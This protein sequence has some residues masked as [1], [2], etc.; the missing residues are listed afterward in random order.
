MKDPVTIYLHRKGKRPIN[1][2]ELQGDEMSY[3]SDKCEKR[4][5]QVL[6]LG[7]ILKDPNRPATMI[8][9]QDALDSLWALAKEME[10]DVKFLENEALEPEIVPCRVLR[11]EPEQ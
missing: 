10:V 2:S 5:Q 1:V 4:K 9:D 7:A 6:A 3:F 8:L 11:E